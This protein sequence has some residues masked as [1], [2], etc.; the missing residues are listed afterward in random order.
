M[1]SISAD[2]VEPYYREAGEGPPYLRV[3]GAVINDD[4]AH[5]CQ[6]PGFSAAIGK[7]PPET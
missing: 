3:M 5:K 1:P 7:F 4:V 2:G 6:D